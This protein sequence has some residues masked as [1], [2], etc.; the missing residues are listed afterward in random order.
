[1]RGNIYIALRA[2]LPSSSAHGLRTWATIFRPSGW[3]IED[4]NQLAY[5]RQANCVDL[6]TVVLL[7]QR[8]LQ[9]LQVR[10]LP[11]FG[12]LLKSNVRKR[13]VEHHLQHLERHG[14]DMR[15]GERRFDHVHGMAQ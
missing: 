13:V 6:S 3:C 4:N 10:L 11:I 1:M 8:L 14:A 7:S 2:R 9:I 5:T 15:S 12:E